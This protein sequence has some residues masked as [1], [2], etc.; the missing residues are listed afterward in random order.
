MTAAICITIIVSVLM[1]FI[2]PFLFAGAAAIINFIFEHFTNPF[3]FTYTAEDGSGVTNW[4]VDMLGADLL[5]IIVKIMIGAGVVLAVFILA[6]NFFKL[7]LSGISK[8]VDSPISL[9]IRAVMAIFLS[10]WII[11]IV[12]KIVFPIFQWLL[13]K[14]NNITVSGS[15]SIMEAI[16]GFYTLTHSTASSSFGLDANSSFMTDIS[17]A[18]AGLSS[19]ISYDI[20]GGLLTTIIFVIFFFKTIISVFK[21]IAEMA[22]RYILINVLTVCSPM[23]M[24]T[25]ISNGTM[26]VFVSWIQMMIANCLVL[27]FNSLGMIMLKAA[28]ISVGI[29]CSVLGNNGESWTSAIMSMIIFVALIKVVQKF[30]VYLAQLAFKIQAIGGDNKGMTISGLL[31]LNSKIGKNAAQISNSGGLKNAIGEKAGN[32]LGVFNGNRSGLAGSLAKGAQDF[33]ATAGARDKEFGKGEFL[34][35]PEAVEAEGKKLDGQLNIA[36]NEELQGKR[37]ALEAQKALNNAATSENAEYQEAKAKEKAGKLTLDTNMLQDGGVVD[38]MT[39][40]E[41]AKTDFKTQLNNDKDYQE[42]ATKEAIGKNNLETSKLTDSNFIESEKQVTLA[43]EFVKG[44]VNDDS[45]VQTIKIA[46]EARSQSIRSRAS[47][48]DLGIESKVR[49]METSDIVHEKV[50]TLR[51]ERHAQESEDKFNSESI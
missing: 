32:F 20:L 50:Q 11:D 13:D 33:K 1:S 30:D 5:N 8:R 15:T 6:F 14:V 45:A 24:P 51:S 29:H 17:S 16:S 40:N 21:L 36:Q 26:Q 7:F 12:Y 46:N 4:F 18:L 10:Y 43:K 25:I 44:Q 48:T 23:I 47:A 39:E 38:A 49:D 42:A 27:I 41:I 35:S 31:A 22:E 19:N 3:R 37:T 34:A 28:F 2:A 9:C